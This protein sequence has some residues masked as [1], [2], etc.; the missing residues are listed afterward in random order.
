MDMII[1]IFQSLGVDQ[2]IFTQFIIVLLFYP[3]I[4]MLLFKKL[5]Y[6]V[7]ERENKTTLLTQEAA[8]QLQEAD[9]LSERYN[10]E[11]TK[12]Y[13][14]SQIRIESARSK[15]KGDSITLIQQ[16]EQVLQAKYM[17]AKENNATEVENKKAGLMDSQEKLTQSLVEKII[18]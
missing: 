10:S 17:K 5:L 4:S 16:E 7:Q 2:T 8:Q 1:G 12:A 13:Q 18:N 15:V 14:E 11:V 6:V 3:I 9:T